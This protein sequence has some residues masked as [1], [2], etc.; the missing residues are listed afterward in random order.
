MGLHRRGFTLVEMVISMAILAIVLIG[1]Q[2][3][4]MMATATA[5]RTARDASAATSTAVAEAMLSADLADATSVTTATGTQITVAVPDRT[6]DG[7]SD[8]VTYSWSGAAGAPIVRTV[9]GTAT[10]VMAGV[11]GFQIAYVTGTGRSAAAASQSAEMLVATN[12]NSNST[13]DVTLSSSKWA[14]VCAKATLPT[15][16]TA[17]TPTR[18]EFQTKPVGLG[19]RDPLSVQLRRASGSAPTSAVL[20]SVSLSTPNL[21]TVYSWRT[22]AFAAGTSL[23]PDDTAAIVLTTTDPSGACQVP[24]QVAGSSRSGD[25]LT[26]SMNSGGSW[27]QSATQAFLYRLYATVTIPGNAARASVYRAVRVAITMAA[28]EHRTIEVTVPLHNQPS[29]P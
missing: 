28:P 8:T 18:V 27:S 7:V 21:T 20:D 29:A 22:C 11:Q 3:A 16:T 12:V 1:G 26:F 9:N 14:A 4:V 19:T 5:R 15:G 23:N 25:V 17:W 13:A 2:S 24:V 10:N 6:G